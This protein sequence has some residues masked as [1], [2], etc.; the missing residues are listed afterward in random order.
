MKRNIWLAI[1]LAG[2]FLAGVLFLT[3]HASNKPGQL[4]VAAQP[5][6]NWNLP[7]A[8]ATYKGTTI[9]LIGEDYPPLQAI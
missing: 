6:A 2:A 1:I 9:R 4:P 7:D 5:G 8:A 3:R